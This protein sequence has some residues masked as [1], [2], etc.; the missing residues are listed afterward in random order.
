MFT[1]MIMRSIHKPYNRSGA[2]YIINRAINIQLSKQGHVIL[3]ERKVYR[4][5]K[6]SFQIAFRK[7]GHTNDRDGN[8]LRKGE[9]DKNPLANRENSRD[10][11]I[12]L[13]CC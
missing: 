12:A 8:A 7:C 5:L 9:K 4:I 11:I 2:L 13:P 1:E 3:P 10:S 6:Y